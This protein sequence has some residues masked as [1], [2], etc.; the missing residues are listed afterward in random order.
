[1]NKNLVKKVLCFLFIYIICFVYSF[2]FTTVYNDEIWNYGFSYNI[3][4]GLVPYK[5]FGMLQTP[6]FFFLASI[7]IKLFGNYLFVF[8]MFNSIIFAGIIYIS[9][10][11]L[12]YKSFILVPMIFLNC[13][14]G[15]NLLSLLILLIIIN[16]VDEEFR[17]KDYIIGF[18]V[19]IMFLTKQ[20]LGVCLLLPLLCYSKN[21]IK[22]LIG[23]L[24]P[25]VLLLIYLI[26]NN[27]LFEFLDYC[28]LG[29]FDFGESNDIWLFFPIE[30]IICLIMVYKLLKSKFKCKELFYILMYQ[31]VTVPIFD[32][33]HFMIGFIPVLFYFLMV[34]KI[35]CYKIKYF[36]IISIFIW[37]C[38]TFMIHEFEKLNFY[39]DKNS[40]L[41]GR[42]VA[43]YVRLDEISDYIRNNSNK[44]DHIYFFSK[45]A[46]YVKLNVSYPLDKYDMICNGNMGYNGSVRYIQEINDFCSDNKCMFI[47]YKYEFDN[48]IVQTNRDIVQ[49]VIDNYR[50][51]ETVHWFDIYVNY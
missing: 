47:L 20:H 44:Y 13:Y 40:Y 33:Y 25:I 14:P 19:G 24:T 17:Y 2:F 38:S 6:L 7:F 30:A 8:H 39:D 48:E 16:L 9:Y 10:N 18:L 41:F 45:N 46:F 35:A 27:A 28:F 50:F 42:N 26:F 34:K 37:F 12:K 22:A 31:I 43:E 29:I 21:K 49:N 23:F 5:D 15:Y 51:Y 3:A 11:K 32:D 4:S 1:M 36:V